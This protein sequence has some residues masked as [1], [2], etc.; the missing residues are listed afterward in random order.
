MK[1]KT[2][3][4]A[5]LALLAGLAACGEREEQAEPI[6]AAAVEEIP[7]STASEAALGFFREG[8]RL[9]D[10]GRILEAR[11]A[12]IQA[13]EADPGFARA[14]LEVANNANSTAEFK[15]SMDHAQMHVEEASEGERLLVGINMAF[16]D[17]D[18]ES[19][20]ALAKELV[21]EYPASPRAYLSLAAVF[22]ALN[23]NQEAREELRRALELDPQMAVAH[24]NLGNSYLYAEP[25]DFELAAQHFRAVVQLTPNE[26]QAHVNLGDA[27][28]G[29]GNLEGARAEYAR[30]AELDPGN[31]KSIY[32]IAVLKR[33][34][35]N[36]FL[37][38]YEEARSDYDQALAVAKP[39]QKSFY[40]N[41]RAFTWVHGGEPATAIQEL[42][43]LVETAAEVTPP[44]QVNAAKIFALTNIAQIAMHHGMNDVAEQAI[45]QRNALVMADAE[46]TGRQDFIR[47][48]QAANAYWMGLAAARRGD[49]TTAVEKAQENAD[50]LQQDA[51]PRKLEPYNDLLGLVALLQGDYAKA[52]EHYERGNP[53]D[54]YVKYHLGLAYEGAGNTG[55]AQRIFRYV[56]E[57][58]F[59]SV[60]YALVRE[61]AE[62]KIA[63]VS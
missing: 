48:Q 55:E 35:V 26:P 10:A 39:E 6:F 5:A 16:F 28:R 40:A 53:N 24:T 33:G 60:G 29:G 61:E 45:G 37:G 34:H 44:D 14:Y 58:N 52:I 43:K 31:Q 59:N 12:F 17:N 13:T 54:I 36:S 30:A 49:F 18:V 38:N 62:R 8:Q 3:P 7:V 2:F 22:G 23:S 63:V 25:K 47:G 1:L 41:Y 32:S 27:Y 56:F 46:A 57:N 4:L 20:L 42:Q 15:E 21:E 51:N 50:L 9:A 11:R 19:A